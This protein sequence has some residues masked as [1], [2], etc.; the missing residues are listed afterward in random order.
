VRN[1]LEQYDPRLVD[2]PEAIVLNK[3]D[4]EEGRERAKSLGP[5]FGDRQVLMLSGA[6]GEGVDELVRLLERLLFEQAPSAPAQPAQE[7]PVLRPRPR[8]VLEVSREDDTYVIRGQQAEVAALKLGDRGPEA[9]DELQKR[10]RRMGLARAMRHEGA[11]PGAQV[12][13]GVVDLVWYG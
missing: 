1:E 9:L 5:Y 13:V 11:R 6:T 2:K 8:T 10:L 7:L 12:R 4:R 3:I